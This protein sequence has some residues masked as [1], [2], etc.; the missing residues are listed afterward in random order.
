M[1]F[2]LPTNG[3]KSLFGSRKAAED[4]R[5]PRPRGG[6]AVPCRAAAS[7]SAAVLCRFLA[8]GSTAPRKLSRFSPLNLRQLSLLVFLASRLLSSADTPLDNIVF[9]VGTTIQDQSAQ[10]WSYVLLGSP[11]PILLS[12]K[13]FGVYSKTGYPTNAGNYTLRGTMVQQ[14]D[15]TALNALLNQSLALGEDTNGLAN[16]LNVFLSSIPGINTMPLPQKI[17]AA[18]QTARTDANAAQTILLI[19][20]LHPGMTLC[21]GHAFSESISA[22]TSYEIR[23]LNS[24][25]GIAGDVVGRVTVLP[26]APVILPAPGPPFQVL[27]N[28]PIDHLKIRL[29]WG[30]PDE[31][32]RLSL[33]SFGYNLWR[34]P[35]AAAESA[36]YQITPPTVAQ[37]YG[38]PNFTRANQNPATTTRDFPATGANDPADPVTVFF[39]DDHG[40]S[41]GQPAFNDGDQFYYFVTARDVLGRD[42]LPS[43]GGLAQACR[44]LL[45]NAPTQVRVANA[46]VQTNQPRFRITW[47]QNTNA[48]DLINEYWIYRWS[49]PASVL[50]NDSAPLSNRVGVVGQ[51]VNTNSN[52]FIDDNPGSP[53]T[54]GATNLWYTIRGV[55]HAGCG[56]L[57]SPHSGPAW[58]VL[59]QRAAPD[60]TDGKVLGSCGTPMV[61]FQ[62]VNLV[63]NS[64]DTNN[65]NY[66]FTCQRRDSGIA[67]VQF[68]SSFGLPVGPVYFPPNGDTVS[69]DVSTAINGPATNTVSCTIG[70]YYGQ[71]SAAV[72]VTLST[73]MAATQRQE[74]VFLAGELL[75]TALNVS[76]PFLLT[77]YCTPAQN[78]TP[79]PS[80]TVHMTFNYYP[81]TPMLIQVLVSNNWVSL[82]LHIPDSNGVYWVSYP[83]CL[84][85]PLPPFQGCVVN[86]P[87]ENSDCIQHI[88]RASADGPVAPIRIQFRLTR[89]TKEYR[90]YRSADGGPLTLLTQGNAPYD[91]SA[92]DKQVVRTDD[93]LPPSASRLCYFVQVLDE[94]GNG[95]PMSFLGCKEVKPAKLPTPVL[96]EPLAAGDTSNP[97]VTLNWFCNT[98]GVYRF[99]VK[100][101]RVD[102]PGGDS[103]GFSST[104]LQKMLNYNPTARYAGLTPSTRFRPAALMSKLL[105]SHFDEAHLTPPIGPNFGPGPQFTLTASLVPNV[106]YNISVAAMD[107]QGNAGD[108]SQV[109]KFTWVPPAA[110]DSVPWPARPVPPL[111]GFSEDVPSHFGFPVQ[112]A[113]SAT[114]LF[115][116]F[117]GSVDQRYP[118]GV[119]IGNL[120]PLSRFANQ[121]VYNGGQ[122]NFGGYTVFGSATAPDPNNLVLTSLSADPARNGQRLLPI[123]LYRVQLANTNFPRVS[124]NIVQVSPLIERI[125]YSITNHPFNSSE[126]TINDRLIAIA[127]VF[128]PNP[129]GDGTFI[130]EMLL[131]DQQP[132]MHGATYM[133][134]VVRFN[135]KREIDEV[136]PTNPVY[137]P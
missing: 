71:S 89:R 109:W 104:K 84:V 129:I 38:D 43:T 94:N 33:L 55:S 67:W 25:T 122:T 26:G 63:T 73:S 32:R 96:A 21:A 93:T 42:G 22:I 30:T 117:T 27:T 100:I 136:I 64:L 86:I 53:T 119:Q 75:E 20:R 6:P 23:E 69:A 41:K 13:Q 88:A 101:E 120:T 134:Y 39:T 61:L 65:W 125:A 34:I 76:D 112:T 12:G 90:L 80:G 137:V 121:I 66:R 92:P 35:R 36:N 44:R 132:A 45:P 8:P 87:A 29:R 85:G 28:D 62:S 91:S 50:T 70:T 118:I 83:A 124:G 17:A 116:N 2:T 79:D 14:T 115:S 102:Q 114:L 48:I 15:T 1:T 68:N 81:G 11:E 49:N 58:G 82:G 54:P 95:S 107:A 37:L 123:V 131:R 106:P 78:P 99:Q 46:T 103:T 98:S 127:N 56:D 135:D 126:V 4:S 31:L 7:W 16:V 108:S 77:P 10:S 133:Y 130:N 74:A 110:V 59:R 24:G 18:F 113:L 72:S 5:T 57:L 19:E 105:L 60:A 47:Q 3:P 128:V 40:H 51:L 111:K 97:Q 52:L 9:S